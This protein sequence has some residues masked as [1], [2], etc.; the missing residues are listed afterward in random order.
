MRVRVENK[1]EKENKNKNEDEGGNSSG[2]TNNWSNVLNLEP[3]VKR[4]I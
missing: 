3:A 2:V 1:N 4:C